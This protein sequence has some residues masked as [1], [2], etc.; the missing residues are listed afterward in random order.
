MKPL[1]PS[2]FPPTPLVSL[3]GDALRVV[4][5]VVAAEGVVGVL[6]ELE[7]AGIT[8]K[9]IGSSLARGSGCSNGISEFLRILFRG[10]FSGVC[11][12]SLKAVKIHQQNIVRSFLHDF[13]VSITIKKCNVS[14]KN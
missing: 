14:F 2:F 3:I 6:E 9:C 7:I 12:I 13:C 4:P 1:C 11:S 5:N 10:E 8:D